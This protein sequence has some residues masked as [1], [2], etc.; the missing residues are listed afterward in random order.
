MISEPIT[1]PFS[2]LIQKK[3]ATPQ[4][5]PRRPQSAFPAKVEKSSP[6]AAEA[7]KWLRKMVPSVNN[8]CKDRHCC[9]CHNL[10]VEKISPKKIKKPKQQKKGYV[11]VV[12]AANK[13]QYRLSFDDRYNELQRLKK[14]VTKKPQN[15]LRGTV[16]FISKIM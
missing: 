10:E 3:A 6:S 7:K 11:H 16:A 4:K 12:T 14:K 2:I 8:S 15:Y 1:V 13:N 9:S 5:K